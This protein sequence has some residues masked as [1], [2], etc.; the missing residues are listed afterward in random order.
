MGVSGSRRVDAAEVRAAL[1][2]EL[3]VQHFGVEVRGRPGGW[4]R[5]RACP[6]CGKVW[7]DLA[8]SGFCIGTRGWT[9]KAC[10]AKGDLMNL[11][12]RL[13]SLD[14]RHDFACVLQLAAAVTGVDAGQLPGEQR[15]QRVAELR[16]ADEAQREAERV[17]VQRQRLAARARAGRLWCRLALDHPR[18]RLY[19]EQRGLDVDALVRRGVARFQRFGWRRSDAP[20]DP[21]VALYDWDGVCLNLVRRRVATDEPK[22]PGQRSMPTDGTLIGRVVQ[23]RPG[24]DV[25][26]TEGVVDS[27]TAV[28]AWPDAV[29][30]GAHGAGHL[31]R[32]AGVAAP[33]I[34]ARG[35]RLLIVP[36]SDRVGQDAAVVAATRALDAGL[37]IGRDLELLELGDRDLNEAW[38]AG[39][40]P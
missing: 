4:W 15:A 30:L 1:T 39:W 3:L 7:R 10:G 27:L 38:R 23:I 40:R 6:A 5:G 33:V 21:T 9:C 18:G 31:A 14:V 19:L 8:G 35:S 22:A 20:G 16:R 32:V 29:V 12:A 17:L 11:L 26:L 25:I 2:R 24:R 37:S 34:R 28:L 36:H 13:A